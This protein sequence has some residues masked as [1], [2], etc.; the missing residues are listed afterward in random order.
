M[1][2]LKEYLSQL[3]K[4]ELPGHID[5]EKDESDTA[6]Q[7]TDNDTEHYVTVTQSKLKPIEILNDKKYTGVKVTREQLEHS[8]DDDTDDDDAQSDDDDDDRDE[9]LANMALMNKQP[10]ISEIEEDEEDLT[11]LYAIEADSDDEEGLKQLDTLKIFYFKI[12]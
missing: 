11:K 10:K 8:S 9:E 12:F 4:E 6:A 3:E 7:V 1:S 2:Q 5:P